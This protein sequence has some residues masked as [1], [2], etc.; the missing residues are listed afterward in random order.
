MVNKCIIQKNKSILKRK[1]TLKGSKSNQRNIITTN[2]KCFE[3][4]NFMNIRNR[5]K[6]EDNRFE[7]QYYTD[8]YLLTKLNPCETR[9]D[10]INKTMNKYNYC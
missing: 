1:V 2:D 3:I 10:T 6:D 4:N 9:N 8:C 7:G 5:S